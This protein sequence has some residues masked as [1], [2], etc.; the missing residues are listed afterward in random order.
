MLMTITPTIGIVMS[1]ME[2]S[3]DK[4]LDN[5]QGPIQTNYTF[6]FTNMN[7]KQSLGH[8]G[9]VCFQE[10]YRITWWKDMAQKQYGSNRRNLLSS[11]PL[12]G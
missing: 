7:Q 4:Y 8:V 5:G 12:K 1:H 6:C 2:K 11:L 3:N 10:H 9:I